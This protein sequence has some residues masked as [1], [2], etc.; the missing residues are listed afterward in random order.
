MVSGFKVQVLP[1][2]GNA[3]VCWVVEFDHTVCDRAPRFD[4]DDPILFRETDEV[5]IEARSLFEAGMIFAA[6]SLG[7]VD[8][9]VRS[10]SRKIEVEVDGLWD[11]F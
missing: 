10:V 7:F 11:E 1:P 2:L 3:T 5:E 4:S 6:Q 9:N 8:L